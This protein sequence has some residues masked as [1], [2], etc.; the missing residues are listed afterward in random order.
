MI[1][2]RQYLEELHAP[3]GG[4]KVKA[5]FYKGGQFT[6]DTNQNAWA[7]LKK[8]DASLTGHAAEAVDHFIGISHDA[9]DNPNTWGG[10]MSAKALERAYGKKFDPE[11]WDDG[12]RYAKDLENAKIVRQELD[13]AFAPVREQLK[14]EIG[15]FVTLYRGQRPVD[16]DGIPVS[17]FD[18]GDRKLLS[19]TSDPDV[20]KEFTGWQQPRRVPSEE[21]IDGIVD[22][23]NK[24]GVAQVKF[25]GWWIKLVPED[26]K[27]YDIFS[28]K[29]EKYIHF[30][31]HVTGGAVSEL[32]Q[33]LMDE[34]QNRIE[35]AEKENKKLERMNVARIPLDDVVW[36]SNRAGQKEFI[37]KNIPGRP[38]Y[39]DTTGKRLKKFRDF[40]TS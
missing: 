3:K 28:V 34:R 19:W 15:P 11:H 7:M 26:H 30:N 37:V 32:R 13:A 21:E 4:L 25:K 10:F 2:F 38:W 12:S 35:D 17:G 18:P 36:I 33:D 31:N 39:I 1:S 40:H 6:P 8:A 20:A 5:K 16:D 9:M 24:K 14:K 23:F 29:E 22:E 27:Y